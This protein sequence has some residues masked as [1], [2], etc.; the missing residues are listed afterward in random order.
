MNL[1]DFERVTD[2]AFS[3]LIAGHAYTALPAERGGRFGGYVR[4][5]VRDSYEIGLMFGDADSSHLCAVWFRDDIGQNIV[6]HNYMQR[7]LFGLLASRHPTFV[8]PTRADLSEE[9]TPESV[10]VKYAES[11]K[12]YAIDV[13]KGDFS[14]FPTLIYVLHHVDRKFPGRPVRRLLGLYSSYDM[15]TAAIADR[16]SKNGFADRAD[17]FEI[18]RMQVNGYGFWSAGIPLDDP[19]DDQG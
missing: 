8:H 18:W 3:F 14:A 12:R 6:Q 9:V 11:L 10:I 16:Q 2:S 13:V 17:G 19:R 15:T 1:S 4:R 5:F 7:G